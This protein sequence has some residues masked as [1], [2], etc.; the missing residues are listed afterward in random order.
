MN[1][2]DI[3]WFVMFYVMPVMLGALFV[4]LRIRIARRREQ[5]NE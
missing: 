5:G 1:E 4:A 3:F 2:N